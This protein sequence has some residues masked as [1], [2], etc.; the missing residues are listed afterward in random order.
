MTW[1]FNLLQLPAENRPIFDRLVTALADMPGGPEYMA[2]GS[3]DHE[4]IVQRLTP[5]MGEREW[6]AP[7]ME[8]VTDMLSYIQRKGAELKWF[9]TPARFTATSVNCDPSLLAGVNPELTRIHREVEE[10]L[11]HFLRAPSEEPHARLG[12]ILVSL[13]TRN[14][15]VRPATLDACLLALRSPIHTTHNWWYLEARHESERGATLELRRVFLDPVTASLAL[16]WGA[17]SS[18][19][20]RQARGRRERRALADRAI[21]AFTRAAGLTD[22]AYSRSRIMRATGAWLALQVP[23]FL[24]AYAKRQ[25]ISH[26]MPEAVWH[27]VQGLQPQHGAEAL[28]RSLADELGAL[29]VAVVDPTPVSRLLAH[30]DAVLSLAGEGILQ[31]LEVPERLLAEWL[32]SWE[33]GGDLARQVVLQFGPRVAEAIGGLSP[34]FSQEQLASIRAHLL[35][36]AESRRLSA[37]SSHFCDWL[38]AST[39]AAEGYRQAE[40]E[41]GSGVSAN[42]LAPREQQRLLDYLAGPHCGIA[43]ARLRE[44]IQDIVQLGCLSMRRSEALKLRTQ[45]YQA[46]PKEGVGLS[47]ISIEPYQGRGLKS[48]SSE[49]LVPAG[50]LQPSV[51]KKFRQ[52]AQTCPADEMLIRPFATGD[53]SDQTVWLTANRVM[54]HYLL[55]PTVHLHHCRHTAATLA[56]IQLMAAPLNLYRYRGRCAFLDSILDEA[57]KTAYCLT[58][59][60]P[61]SL[62]HLRVVSG[63]LGH[64]DPQITMETYI[65]SC[66]LLLYFA[67]DRSGDPGYIEMLSLASG[68]SEDSIKAFQRI[69]E[70]AREPASVS[71]LRNTSRRVTDGYGVL[72]HLEAAYPESVARHDLPLQPRVVMSGPG[73]TY[74]NILELMD[75]LLNNAS[76][77]DLALAHATLQRHGI[78]GSW[79]DLIKFPRGRALEFAEQWA[80]RLHR[81]WKA[82][83]VDASDELVQGMALLVRRLDPKHGGIHLV[84]REVDATVHL[85]TLLRGCGFKVGDWSIRPYQTRRSAEPPRKRLLKWEQ[86]GREPRP[87][88]LCPEFAERFSY[89]GVRWITQ[90]FLL[91]QAFAQEGMVDGGQAGP[92]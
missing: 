38:T 26:S 79:A 17:S 66:D 68:K 39:W 9:A 6:P 89:E 23:P 21:R 53:F 44:I 70:A 59:L 45:D 2:T 74:P 85:A 14:A 3:G 41:D 31:T 42:I 88:H 19:L 77:Q 78:T 84:T 49:R 4:D 92:E 71:R 1:D 35:E 13:I 20:I 22:R 55:D 75:R 56:L 64:L 63:L 83:D 91:F 11:R 86:L 18:E 76:E 81:C 10:G 30:L 67:L 36:G 40:D 15:I 28:Q 51:Q 34:P 25:L 73:P 29:P 69:D 50:L 8:S 37:C 32:Q 57:E 47:V 48:A 52:V 90:G 16:R 62:N 5:Y 27:R 80:A 43:D 33:P 82:A 7:M 65:H 60:N 24:N 46:T 54:Q 72:R 87:F 12:A 58:C 61:S